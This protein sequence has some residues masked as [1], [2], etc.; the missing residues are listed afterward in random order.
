[1]AAAMR[2]R[3]RLLRRLA[4]LRRNRC[5]VLLGMLIVAILLAPMLTGSAWG[6]VS[7]SLVT[8]AILVLAVWALRARRLTFW[9][10][11]L[12][13]LV[14]AQAIAADWLGE[15]WLRPAVPPLTALL[16]GAVTLALLRYVLDG[17]RSRPTRCSARWPLM[18]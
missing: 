10:I 6:V 8:L 12:L 11:G 7:L 17:G 4:Y 9:A 2:L 16:L 14:A 18:C 15:H 1:M 3:R 13:A 5:S